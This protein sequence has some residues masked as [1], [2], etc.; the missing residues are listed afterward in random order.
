VGFEPTIPA[1]E[2]AQTVHALDGSATVT[3][4]FTCLGCKYFCMACSYEIPSIYV[5]SVFF[6][7]VF[8]KS[9]VF[10]DVKK[11]SPVEDG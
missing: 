5:R 8:M 1:A 3:G 7:A 9:T 6:P 2:R 10:W 11:Y 4:I